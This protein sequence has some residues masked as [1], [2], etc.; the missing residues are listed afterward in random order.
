ML[1]FSICI[2]DM[3]R[4]DFISFS[5]VVFE[6]CYVFVINFLYV[7]CSKMVEFMMMEEMSYG[8]FFDLYLR[9]FVG[10]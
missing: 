3:V 5:D 10:M 1:I 4:N 9:N 8:L 7:F 2:S 6:S